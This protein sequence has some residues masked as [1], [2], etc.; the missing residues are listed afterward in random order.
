MSDFKIEVVGAKPTKRPNGPLT[1]LRR[2][3]V[4]LAWAALMRPRLLLLAGLAAL[5]LFVGTPHAGWDYECNHTMRGPG[6]CRS[7]AWCAYY[8]IQGRRI[9]FPAY[10]QSCQLFT[11][12]PLD[13]DRLTGGER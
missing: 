1:R 12:L 6:S 13:W 8:G 11:V 10:G 7:V 3:I 2:R 9:E 4:R 5:V